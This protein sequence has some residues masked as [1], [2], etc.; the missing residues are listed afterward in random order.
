MYVYRSNSL[1]ALAEALADVVA[2]PLASPFVP[3]T[4]VVPARSVGVWLGLRLAERHGVWATPRFVTAAQL[5]DSLAASS[6]DDDPFAPAGLTWS[7]AAALPALVR[8]APFASVR[9][10]LEADHGAVRRVALSERLG[11]VFHRYLSHRPD[12]LM[13]W[14]RGTEDA[15]DETAAWQ[16]RLWRALVAR[17][18]PDHPG[19]R[20]AALVEALR[21]GGALDLP[22]RV[23]V[24]APEA[25]A[26]SALDVLQ[27]LATRIPV[28]VF[29]R[30]GHHPLAA[31][32][33]VHER[34][35]NDAID[36][37][38]PTAVQALTVTP[39]TPTLG[40]HS[41]HS[42]MRECEVLRDQLLALFD[43][44]R[45]LE[46]RDV[47]V[48]CPDLDTYAPVIDAV[49]G[50]PDGERGFVPYRVVD[51]A[52]R[53]QRSVVEAFL[54][55]L[56]VAPSRLKASDVVDLLAREPIRARFDL[57]EPD[58]DLVRRW[59]SEAGIRWAEDAAHRAEVGQPAFLENTWRFGLDRL[60]LGYA[61]GKDGA[62]TCGECLPY[63]DVEGA[64]SAALG[65]LAE[66]CEALFEIRRDLCASARAPLAAWRDRLRGA[67]GKLVHASWQTELQHQMI[68]EALDG[69]VAR[70][71]RA[72]F[73]DEVPL[74]VVRDAL[75]CEL[76]E[77]A[78]ALEASI[79]GVTFAALAS[80]RCLPARVVAMLGM[81]DGDVPRA[82]VPEGF[83]L[84]ARHPR[85]LDPC[86]RDDDRQAFVSA[87]LSARDHVLVTYVGQ[88][89]GDNK[90][91]PPSV[92]VGQLLDTLPPEA[93][94]GAVVRHPLHAF[95][96]RYFG[97]GGDARLFSYASGACDAARSMSG[98]RAARPRFVRRP[99]SP[100]SE[101]VRA[102]SVD[103][104]ARFFEHPVRAF[105]QARL[106]V[107]LGS[108]VATLEDREPLALG[109][110][111]RWLLASP[112]LER[113]RRGARLE[114]GLP[115]DVR[116]EG[117]LPL[118]VVG[119]VLFDEV[120][121]EVRAIAERVLALLG[122]QRVEPLPVERDV[123]GEADDVT[124]V[125][126][127]LEGVGPRAQVLYTYSKSTGARQL[128]AWV[129]HVLLQCEGE[130]RETVL[131]CA[132]KTSR[133]APVADPEAVLEGLVAWYWRGL[134][135]PLSLFP[136]AAVAWIGAE[137]R[138]GEAALS[139]A[140]RA[141]AGRFGECPYV[142][143]AFGDVADAQPLAPSFEPFAEPRTPAER[144]RF[145][146]FMELS[147]LIVRPMT[148]HRTEERT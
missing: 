109:P 56:D 51:R 117:K 99:L 4:I 89:I 8:E 65:G 82:R 19:R 29:A 28:H 113:A 17:H 143:R 62:T 57:E 110:L 120:V 138:G 116:A 41:C 136:D 61:M 74:S 64:S 12:L 42:P 45:T 93:R 133:F 75:R 11:R 128:G 63:D 52:A 97:E 24:F 55:L 146:A 103:A 124:R 127:W 134:E 111:E 58:I 1:T 71:E 96:P 126:G 9:G 78:R 48:L 5:V 60:V 83:D 23:S 3:E 147:D 30:E 22:E 104:L 85:P 2:E 39:S 131:V 37:R 139:A 140:E 33:S 98:P 130:P 69:L 16:A 44:D 21:D 141:F 121:P 87:L 92:L 18:G 72:G 123:R 106:G 91:R 13:G 46:A 108:D 53:E 114:G 100:V 129:R 49:F 20:V 137:D 36:A 80:A 73:S 54:A 15:G 101:A 50:V 88:S 95:S 145:P 27:A 66:F 31:S 34:Q 59:I 118:G 105:F 79:G 38:A 144:A 84:L 25:L 102:V 40:V 107:S 7:I 119:E 132:D 112:L 122:P 77:R 76:D 115:I 32:L 6:T 14:E 81:N 68:R 86:P 70:A 148:Q 94:E 47:L 43:A 10:Y 67:L 142:R 90:E 35:L 135:A 26:A 125:S